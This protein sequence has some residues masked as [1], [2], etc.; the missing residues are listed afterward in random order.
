MK[1]IIKMS[2]SHIDDMSEDSD[3]IAEHEPDEQME[4]QN[5][6]PLPKHKRRS[7]VWRY[8]NPVPDH[9]DVYRCTICNETFG[10]KTA[11]LGRHLSTV[12][13]INDVVSSS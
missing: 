6:I 5:V 7:Y 9:S 2:Q 12:H 4:S 13:G 1:Q 10:N 11:N 3:S 8:F